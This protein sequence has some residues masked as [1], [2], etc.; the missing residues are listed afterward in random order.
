MMLTMENTDIAARYSQYNWRPAAKEDA[1]QIHSLLLERDR[2]DEIESAGTLEDIRREFE[3]TWLHNIETDTLVATTADGKLVIMALVFANPQPVEK[4][5]AYLWYEVH[6]EHR[7]PG[8]EEALLVWSMQRAEAILDQ[9]P[10]DLPRVLGINAHDKMAWRVDLYGKLGFSAERYFYTMRRDLSQPLGIATIDS[11][12]SMHVYA[13]G[14]DEALRQAFNDSF[15]DHWNFEPVSVEDWQ[16]WFTGGLHFRPDL[17]YLVLDG[18]Q[19]A[20]FSINSVSPEKNRQRGVNEG[21]INQLGTRR[22]WRKRGIATALLLKSMQA[23]KDEGLEYATLGVDTE[24]PTGALRIYEKVGFTPV[25]RFIAFQMFL[26][27]QGA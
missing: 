8:I 14:Q 26:D 12:L 27:A 21:W 7:L 10:S 3:D 18:D 4:R 24:N 23:F 2:L 9:V 25:R 15:M 6:P 20:G 22:G 5:F 11:G 17:T 16:K 19:I 1:S 13:P